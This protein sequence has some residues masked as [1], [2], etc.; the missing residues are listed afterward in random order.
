MLTRPT[1]LVT[2]M[3]RVEARWALLIGRRA[4]GKS[5]LAARVAATLGERG[6]AVG[7]VIQ[8]AVEEDGTCVGIRVRRIGGD[9]HALLARLGSAPRDG[10]EQAFC[11]FVFDNRAFAAARDW[12]AADAS[13]AAVLII[14]EVSKLEAARSG[15]C[16][17][18]ERALAAAAVVVLVVRAEELS[19]VMERFA[20][21]EPIAALDAGEEAG[22]DGFVAAI[23]A[24]AQEVRRTNGRSQARS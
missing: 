9:E 6:L 18:V 8:D 7:G 17:A 3:G 1:P 12:I 15:H 5:S 10:N 11:S 19:A 14:D 24:A 2:A 4:S 21:D 13:S 22:I 16:E 23:A 20:L